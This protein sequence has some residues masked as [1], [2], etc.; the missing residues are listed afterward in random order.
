M[1]T[2]RS[3]MHAFNQ[4]IVLATLGAPQLVAAPAH[5][6]PYL[7]PP[8]EK[9]RL[10]ERLAPFLLAGLTAP[11]GEV[12]TTSRGGKPKARRTRQP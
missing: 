8:T 4:L 9:Q 3:T 7:M 2:I 10:L 6:H 12:A 11:L 1:I 5:P